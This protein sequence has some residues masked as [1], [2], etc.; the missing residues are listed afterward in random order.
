MATP[1]ISAE[2]GD[3]ATTVLMPGD[4]LRAKFIAETFLEDAKCY[5]QVRG[6]LGYTGYY[7]GA[8]VSIQGSGMG[9]PSM[10]IYSYELFHFYGV[11]NIIRI[12]TCGAMNEKV[13]LND[14][15]FAQGSSTDS[16][17]GAQFKASGIISA[18]ADYTLLET[19]VQVARE[20]KVSFHVGNVAS[21]DTFYEETNTLEGWTK[22]GILAGEMESYGLYLNAARCGKRALAIMTASDEMYSDRH[23]SIEERQTAYTDMMKVALR[24]A[25]RMEILQDK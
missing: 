23:A 14:L 15:I 13:K 4:P 22:M 8:R 7:Q 9:I 2:L 25:Q 3:I 5:T 6:M 18:L 10:A 19:A 21:G 17:F 24:T 12:G 20:E 16:N 11:N 1:H